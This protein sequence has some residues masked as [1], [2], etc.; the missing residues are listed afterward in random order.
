MD[1]QS[2]RRL[3]DSCF[4]AKNVIETMKELP[5][6]FKPRHIHVV[7]AVYELA[8]VQEEVRVSDISQYLNITTPSVPKLI[9]ELEKMKAL[10]KD[11]QKEDK[12]VSLV[13]L[14]DYGL[15]L[16]EKYVTNYHKEWADKL[17]DVTQ[18]EEDTMIRV[19]KRLSETMPGN[20]LINKE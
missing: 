6:G 8:R 15:E 19:I 2:I 20:S 4:L 12:R 3:L 11:S 18:D 5:K 7:E 14:T 13:C 16:Q 10:K 17:Q 1:E 9:Q